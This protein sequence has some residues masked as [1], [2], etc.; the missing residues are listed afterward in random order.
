MSK[1][2]NLVKFIVALLLTLVLGVANLSCAL[3]K[4]GPEGEITVDFS[5]KPDGQLPTI[6][7]FFARPSSITLGNSTTIEWDVSRATE[8][9]IDQ[10]IGSVVHAGSVEVSPM[11]TETFT[12]TANNATGSV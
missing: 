8:V 9:S 11:A 12:L 7:L 3:V 1:T 10:G 6:N 2:K 5:L 4:I